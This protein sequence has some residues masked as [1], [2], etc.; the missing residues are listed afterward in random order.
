MCVSHLTPGITLLRPQESEGHLKSRA[1]AFPD[2][3]R[4]SKGLSPGGS[5]R[6]W[7]R[8]ESP[9]DNKVAL[10][11]DAKRF[12]GSKAQGDFRV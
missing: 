2:L 7:D 1:G 8:L 3:R 12:T 10:L 11:S 9:K 5:Q 6:V 4:G